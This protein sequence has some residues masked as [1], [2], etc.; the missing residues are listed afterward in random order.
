MRF[1]SGFDRSI[2][3]AMLFERKEVQVAGHDVDDE[4]A[5]PVSDNKMDA[6]LSGR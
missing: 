2:D 4:G 3:V 5:V 6:T 1:S